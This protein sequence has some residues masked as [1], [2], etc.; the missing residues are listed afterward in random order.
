MPS[1][2][3]T[4]VL[5]LWGRPLHTLRWL[6]HY[7]SIGFPYPILIADGGDDADIHR[8][9]LKPELFPNLRY[10]YL[11][12]R[13]VVQQD[14]WEKGVD[15]L[16]RV[17][18]PYVVMVDNDDFMIPS[19]I[20][21]AVRFLDSHPDHV[22][23]GGGISNFALLPDRE[24]GDPLNGVVGRPYRCSL[25]PYR[26][27]QGNNAGERVRAFLG[28]RCITYYYV[29]RTEAL[30]EI[31]KAVA[32]KRAVAYDPAETFMSL[33]SLTKGPGHYDGAALLYH[34][35][36]GSSSVHAHNKPWTHQLFHGRWLA[37]LQDFM[38]AV[39][40]EV[41]S[42][43][44]T[45]AESERKTI[46][47][48][49]AVGWEASVA[50]R[51]GRTAPRWRTA[52]LGL[53][54]RLRNIGPFAKLMLKRDHRH[55][56]ATLAASGADAAALAEIAGELAAIEASLTDPTFVTFVSTHAPELLE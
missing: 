50:A 18:T 35:Q 45:D 37:E 42:R 31:W 52:L 19:G 8:L 25:A 24:A 30:H 56:C 22:F 41:A 23:A 11:R 26:L 44:G 38:A 16:S 21:A 20:A 2:K 29:H 34:R 47:D 54:G 15:V 1:D 13:D 55:L 6:R 39:A 9:L 33:L 40:A 49:F 48:R 10:Q 43:D 53:R 46:M 51:Y 7:D 32:D 3:L 12:Y 14:F 27:P 28:N 4:I 17:Q 36:L 5:T